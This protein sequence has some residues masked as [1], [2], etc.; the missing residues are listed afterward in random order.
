MS[1]FDF[2]PLYR[3][4]V[5]F[6][7]LASMIDTAARLDGAQGYPPYNIE[8]SIEDENA[9]AIELAVAGFA[10]SDLDLEVKEGQ[11]IV[12]GKKDGN[13]TNRKFLHRGVAERGFIR[14]FQLADHVVVTGAVLKNGLLRIELKRELPEAMKPRKI[15]IGDAA[16]TQV[17][18]GSH[19][20]IRSASAA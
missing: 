12:I 9:Y 15:A 14:R 1:T 19:T 10:E 6:D 17:I 16:S 20:K 4:V 2:S 13:D 5:G 18:D 7:R 11:L 3:T 8:Q